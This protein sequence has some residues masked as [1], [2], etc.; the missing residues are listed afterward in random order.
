MSICF[1]NFMIRYG[2]TNSRLRIYKNFTSSSDIKIASQKW[3]LIFVYIDER[4]MR[5][6][7]LD[8]S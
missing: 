3:T 8:T 5:V 2:V 1:L 7:Y 4:F 6:F